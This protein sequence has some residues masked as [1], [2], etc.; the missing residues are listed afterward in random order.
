MKNGRMTQSE[1]EQ[2]LKSLKQGDTVVTFTDN[3]YLSTTI[4]DYYKVDKI[5]PKGRLRL[6]NGVLLDENGSNFSKRI[7]IEPYDDLVKQYEEQSD[8]EIEIGNLLNTMQGVVNKN[9]G[10]KTY[11]KFNTEPKLTLERYREIRNKLTECCNLILDN[12]K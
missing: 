1:R 9:A 7:K 12:C 3:L 10:L 6:D 8:L 4:I 11:F 2:W 5:T